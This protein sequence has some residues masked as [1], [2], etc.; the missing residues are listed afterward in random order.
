MWTNEPSGKNGLGGLFTAACCAIAAATRTE[1]SAHSLNRW[2]LQ[3]FCLTLFHASLVAG[4]EQE[5]AESPQRHAIYVAP[6]TWHNFTARSRSNFSAKLEAY[7]Q[8]D[9]YLVLNNGWVLALISHPNGWVLRLL[10][11]EHS[12]ALDLSQVTP[13]FS[14]GVPNP[15][16][17]F[18][19]HFR[20]R[21]NSGLNTGEVNAPQLLRLF[22]FS[23]E[24][25]GTGGFKPSNNA[26]SL[27]ASGRG[28]FKILDYGLGDLDADQRASMKYLRF[29]ACLSW[30]KSTDQQRAE[31]DYQSL[32][33]T[34]TE[35]EYFTQCGL[36]FSAFE[37]NPVDT[38]PRVLSGDI[39]GDGAIDQ[40][41]RVERIS[42]GVRGIAV[43]RAG[44]WLKLLGFDPEMDQ[45]LS[46]DLR[47]IVS[48]FSVWYLRQRSDETQ[49]QTQL[50]SA[51]DTLVLERPEKGMAWLHWKEGSFNWQKAYSVVTQEP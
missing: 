11:R 27:Q 35:R 19:W 31:A 15:R 23:P 50:D 36:D 33:Y 39:D 8:N 22:Q 26:Q 29:E 21:D 6:K 34:A 10:D 51:G 12:E 43:C 45:G 38:R 44:T 3:I 41:V 42:D 2:C 17:L 30:P 14:A 1:V 25:S 20:N 46:G 49:A 5:C 18:G 24:L 9:F 4:S 40:L 28:W 47:H 13:P 48:A 37:L 32:I 7:G 16:D